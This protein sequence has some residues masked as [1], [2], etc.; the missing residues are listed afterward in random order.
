MI[1]TVKDRKTRG[2]IVRGSS[3]KC[4]DELGI[5]LATFRSYRYLGGTNR[6]MISAEKNDVQKDK[7]ESKN[8]CPCNS[9]TYTCKSNMCQEWCSWFSKEWNKA[10]ARLRGEK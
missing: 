7:D 4:A 3:K 5:C 2:V 6:Y 10:I 8:G 1:Y 9:C